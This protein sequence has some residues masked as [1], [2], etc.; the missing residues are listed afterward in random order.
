MTLWARLTW[1]AADPAE[2]A[3]ELAH[4]LG[5][6][7]ARDDVDPASAIVELGTAALE[8]APWR[9]EAPTDEP[10]PGGR[11]VF[12]PLALAMDDA[13]VDDSSGLVLVA[14]GWAT[15]DLDRAELDLAEWLGSGPGQSDDDGTDPHL[16][17]RVRLRDADGLPGE[18]IAL[19]EPTTEGRLAASLARDGEGPCALYLWPP[20]GLEPWIAAADRRGVAVSTR[21]PGPFGTS[22]LVVAGPVAGPHLVIVRDGS[23][24]AEAPGTIRP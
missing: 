9:K 21:A 2:L 16:G 8:I 6:A 22:V 11:L 23:P 18:M 10:L 19:L 15:V 4:R 13:R 7:A 12:E 14:V 24:G 17:A 3:D 5:V 1:Q 20:G